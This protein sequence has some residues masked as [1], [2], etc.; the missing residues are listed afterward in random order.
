MTIYFSYIIQKNVYLSHI[1]LYVV[2]FVQVYVK[3]HIFV[4]FIL[5]CNYSCCSHINCTKGIRVRKQTS[6][7]SAADMASN[8]SFL[9]TLK[10]ELDLL[11]LVI[12]LFGLTCYL[13]SI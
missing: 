9:D 5:I 13:I 11:F 1:L 4:I 2:F 3:I 12:T 8:Q 7:L 10:F 6:A